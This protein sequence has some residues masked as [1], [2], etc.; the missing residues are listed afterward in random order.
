MYIRI[1]Q[2]RVVDTEFTLPVVDCICV[3]WCRV[4]EGTTVSSN[5]SESQMYFYKAEPKPHGEEIS[6]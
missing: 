2:W 5:K 6:N 3:L 4:V 1:E